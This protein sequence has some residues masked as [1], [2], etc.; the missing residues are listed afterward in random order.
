MGCE[1]GTYQVPGILCPMGFPRVY[2][3]FPVLVTLVRTINI[4][5]YNSEVLTA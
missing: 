5:T 3:I 1:H 4:G 2:I